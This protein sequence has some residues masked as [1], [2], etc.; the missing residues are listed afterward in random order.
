MA[1]TS[2]RKLLADDEDQTQENTA[3]TTSAPD[4]EPHRQRANTAAA[5][6]PEPSAVEESA[7]A[8]QKP[9]K[10]SAKKA[11]E[12]QAPKKV[13]FTVLLPPD[14]HEKFKALAFINKESM[15]AMVVEDIA[16]RVT[17]MD[18]ILG[19]IVRRQKK[20]DTD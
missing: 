15:N 2:R 11:E 8:R 13:N 6:Q 12:K 10:K 20:A 4:S 1:H 17:E 16:K 19:A 9:A 18:S 5:F 7:P 14:L 3:E